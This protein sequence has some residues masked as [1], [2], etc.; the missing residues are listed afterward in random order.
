MTE[1]VLLLTGM[2]GLWAGSELMVR[3][4]S[5]LTDRY[6]LSDAAFGMI[7]LAIGTDLPELFVAVDASIRSIGGD[8]LSGIVIGSAVG[9]SI[10]QFGLVFGLGG[11][12]GFHAMRRR[13][14]ARNAFFLLGSIAALFVFSYDGRVTRAE[15]VALALFYAT[16]LYVLITRRTHSPDASPPQRDGPAPARAWITLA[17][18]LVLLWLAAELTVASAVAFGRIVGLSNLAVSAIVIGMGSSLPELSVSIAALLQKRARLSAGNLVGSNV[19]DT[20]LVPGL[21]AIISPLAVAGE[22]LLIDLPVLAVITTLVI[23]FLY[24]SR[25]GV[26]APEGMLLLAVYASYVAVRL[27]AADEVLPAL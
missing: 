6:Y 7:V 16:Y 19:L 10:G 27:T 8:N 20:L 17:A 2:A 12:F 13:F 25:R 4:A 24:V 3:S 9:S 21:A 11:F 1:F 18:A 23:G 15:G 5:A 26:R 22:V 14:L